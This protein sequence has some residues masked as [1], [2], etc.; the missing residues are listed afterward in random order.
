MN[1]TRWMTLAGSCF[2]AVSVIAAPR[3]IRYST[4]TAAERAAMLA[5]FKQ[6]YLTG[7]NGVIVCPYG[8]EISASSKYVHISGKVLQ[9]AETRLYRIEHRDADI[10]VKLATSQALAEG[11]GVDGIAV[12]DGVYEYVTVLGAKRTLPLYTMVTVGPPTAEHV[13]AFLQNGGTL[14][15]TY[16]GSEKCP[17]C[18]GSRKVH[19]EKNKIGFAPCPTCQGA[20]AIAKPQTADVVW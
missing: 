1:D 12:R 16:P 17:R 18:R 20:G 6:V 13:Q 15:T 7:T 3:E 2:V 9:R 19:A 5:H 8:A 4:A 10:A 11:D 14:S